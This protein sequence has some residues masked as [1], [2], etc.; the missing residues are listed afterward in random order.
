MSQENLQTMT[1]QN[2]WGVK[3]VYYG[4]VQVV[5]APQYEHT[6]FVTMAI[7]WVPDLPDIKGFAGHLWHSVLIFAKWCLICIIQQAY[8]YIRLSLWP[9]LK[10]F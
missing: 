9:L 2:F 6:I 7:Y 5:N 3:E 10:V 8:E 4:I 1:M